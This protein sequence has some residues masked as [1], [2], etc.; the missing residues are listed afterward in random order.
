MKFNS[1]ILG[2]LFIGAIV[3]AG[4]EREELFFNNE[5]IPR[6]RAFIQRN[7]LPYDANFPTNKINHHEVEFF[8]NRP[9]AFARMMLE[10]KHAFEFIMETNRVEIRGYKCLDPSVIRILNRLDRPEVVKEWSARTNM[11]N[12]TTALALARNYFI[13]QGHQ[14][15]NFH[16]IEFSQVTCGSLKH[17]PTNFSA[18]P[19]YQAAWYRKDVT[20]QDR[21]SGNARL[22]QV[23]IFVSGISSNLSLYSKLFMP[24][25]S[26][27]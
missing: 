21:E 22:P 27:F 5:M 6:V 11:L 4:G 19:F 10:K 14:E 25:G 7:G 3:L 1:V 18:L 2:L 15:K 12:E 13:L 24:I 23:M 8:S 26:D 17:D 16:S 9:A 20:K